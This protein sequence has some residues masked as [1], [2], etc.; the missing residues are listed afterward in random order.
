MGRF[1]LAQGS[2]KNRKLYKGFVDENGRIVLPG[3]IAAEYGLKPGAEFFIESTDKNML[4]EMFYS[5]H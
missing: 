4:S 2:M 1:E 3:E 5:S